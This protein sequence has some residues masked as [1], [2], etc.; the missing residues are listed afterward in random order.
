MRKQIVGCGTR[1]LV[2]GDRKWDTMG[3]SWE[4]ATGENTWWEMTED[5]RQ[6]ERVADGTWWETAGGA[7]HT[8]QVHRTLR[9]P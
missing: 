9:N 7:G 3:N 6:W 8:G 4:Y 2:A 1:R 5:G